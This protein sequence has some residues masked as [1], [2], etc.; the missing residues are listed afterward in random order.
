[1]LE[2][3]IEAVAGDIASF[4]FVMVY[5]VAFVSAGGGRGKAGVKGGAL[6][7]GQD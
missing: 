5:A 1:M 4:S 6:C 7:Q 2:S 3:E